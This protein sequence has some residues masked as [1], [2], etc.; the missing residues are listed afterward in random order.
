MKDIYDRT[1]EKW[2]H[3]SQLEMAQEEA[4]EK[5][6]RSIFGGCSFMQYLNKKV[7]SGI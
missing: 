4:T 1:I 5:L 3:R 6:I 7:E 2:G